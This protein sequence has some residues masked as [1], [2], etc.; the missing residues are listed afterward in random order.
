LV[1]AAQGQLQL[2]SARVIN[3][4]FVGAILAL[5]RASGRDIWRLK[6]GLPAK[7]GGSHLA[8]FAACDT[9]LPAG[10][11]GRTSE[12]FGILPLE[13]G[14]SDTFGIFV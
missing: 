8:A 12:T 13:R 4:G 3:V 1:Y 7:F 10:A 2:A 5:K 11:A 14:A 6:T 9:L